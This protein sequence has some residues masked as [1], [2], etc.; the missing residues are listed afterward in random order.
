[1]NKI[2]VLIDAT[3][4]TNKMTGVTRYGIEL[5]ERFS[6][7]HEMRFD[8]IISPHLEK[9]HR[10]FE[11]FP[12]SNSKFY[13][14]D[15]KGI[16][17]I[18]EIKF[19]KFRL[20]NMLRYDIFHSLVTNAPFAF[21]GRSV[22]TIHDLKYILY[23]HYFGRFFL[24]KKLFLSMQLV[25]SVL[26]YKKLICVSMT[27]RNDLLNSYPI[28]KNKI[29]KKT[30]VIHHGRNTIHQLEEM[31]GLPLKYILC[32]G[33]IRPHKNVEKLIEA[34]YQVRANH[35][36]LNL[37]IVG[38]KHESLALNLKR[39]GISY[40]GSVGD[41][42]LYDI[43]KKSLALVFVSKYEG[44]GFPLVEA[45]ELGVPIISGNASCLPEIAGKAALYVDHSSVNSIADGIEK[46]L[47]DEVLSKSLVMEGY[48]QALK[49]DWQIAA[50]KT[51][52][53]YQSA[54]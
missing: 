53:V 13:V 41:E 30:V 21:F 23:P 10:L 44:F 33:E 35:P 28:L 8:F 22:S 36:D 32:L 15:V 31:K 5:L 34:F 3:T 12:E 27:T 26:F 52:G 9:S 43:Y 47:S 2:S 45:M 24:V 19:I 42:F 17:P 48:E 18:R 14:L 29:L 39:E 7:N 49:Y 25:W 54:L 46:I 11:I 51:L 40:L 37:V 4:L 16:G 20:F 38:K 6:D 1:M 50:D